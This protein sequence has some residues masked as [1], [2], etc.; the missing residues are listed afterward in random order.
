MVQRIPIKVSDEVNLALIRLKDEG[1]Y[2]SLDEALR[3]LLGLAPGQEHPQKKGFGVEDNASIVMSSKYPGITEQSARNCQS[4]QPLYMY[5][6]R[7]AKG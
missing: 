4:G 6:K 1:H 2:R 5:S 3:P 7:T